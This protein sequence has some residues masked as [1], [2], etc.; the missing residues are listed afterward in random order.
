[1]RCCGTHRR[2]RKRWR[3]CPEVGCLPVLLLFPLGF[4]IGYLVAGNLGAIWGAGIGLL[5]GVLLMIAF[6]KALRGRR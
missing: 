5:L 2:R 1:M 4:G 6:I 3:W